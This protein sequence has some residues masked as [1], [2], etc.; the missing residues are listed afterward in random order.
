[1]AQ[2]L[3]VGDKRI[4]SEICS[5]SICRLCVVSRAHARNL[6]AVAH[7]TMKLELIVNSTKKN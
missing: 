3:A 2:L 5:N 6:R 4:F 7:I 1:M